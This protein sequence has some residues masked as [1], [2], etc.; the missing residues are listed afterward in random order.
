MT[1][2]QSCWQPLGSWKKI[3]W[4]G[5]RGGAGN[6]QAS[7]WCTFSPSSYLEP[8]YMLG[9][10]LSPTPAFHSGPAPS[11]PVTHEHQNVWP[12]QITDRRPGLS[13]CGPH[14]SITYQ[15]ADA[16]VFRVCLFVCFTLSG[17]C[18]S[19]GFPSHTCPMPPAW[20]PAHALGSETSRK[21]LMREVG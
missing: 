5:L 4:R 7:A 18:H 8:Q 1:S 13:W 15:M 21:S 14:Y 3:P 17:T 12:R 20:W 2:V 11:G 19:Q 6:L 16:L 10:S 9:A